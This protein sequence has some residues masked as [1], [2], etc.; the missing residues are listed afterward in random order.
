MKYLMT[1]AVSIAFVGIFV[2]ASR[3]AETGKLGLL[4]MSMGGL[5]LLCFVASLI[6]W[7]E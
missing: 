5:I 4:S 1:T 6:D 3:L 2:G 7:S